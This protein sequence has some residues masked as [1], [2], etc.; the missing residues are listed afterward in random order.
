MKFT[1][2]PKGVCSRAINLEIDEKEDIILSFSAVGGCSGNL[3][4]IGRLITGMPVRQ[5]IDRLKGVRCGARPTSCP[6]QLAQALEQ[7][8]AEKAQNQ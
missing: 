6:D 1:F 2:T 4:G 3:R 8:L 7:Y 5:V